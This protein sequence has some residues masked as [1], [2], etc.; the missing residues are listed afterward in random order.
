MRTE[1]KP[2]RKRGILRGDIAMLSVVRI[3]PLAPQDKPLAF[4]IMVGE[5]PYFGISKSRM[6]LSKS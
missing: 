1:N 4:L 5:P 3:P 2:K 6:V